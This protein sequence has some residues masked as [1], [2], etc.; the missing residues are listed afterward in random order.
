MTT[1]GSCFC[2]EVGFEV[3]GE[4]IAMGY[5]HCASCRT[6]LGAPVHGFTMWEAQAVTVTRGED[7]VATFL[8]TPD[9]ISHR[10]HCTVC[11]G[12]LMVRHPSMGLIDI[13]SVNVPG[14]AF[15]PQFHVN[16]AEH[17]LTM[18]DGLPKFA[19]FPPDFGGSGEMMPE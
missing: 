7:K 19:G 14:V 15:A 13:P 17:V 11:G 10:Q 18:K 16:Y 12:S 5:C 1:K 8:K 9:S 6:W 2:G 4:P 3:E